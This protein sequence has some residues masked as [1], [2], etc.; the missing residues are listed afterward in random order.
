V[1]PSINNSQS[2]LNISECAIL[3][4]WGELPVQARHSLLRIDKQALFEQARKN[5]YCSRCNGLLLESFT[6]I[7]MYGKSLQ[8]H[9]GGSLGNSL[10][11]ED[12]AQDPAVHPWGGL[13]ATKDGLLTLL[14]C[15]INSR[16][17][18]PLQNVS[19]SI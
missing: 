5:L 18:R 3:Q 2:L 8:Q 9:R 16:S 1:F 13:A 15:F 11:P 6:Q 17:L 14:D 10:D 4:F 19:H 7:V 12:E